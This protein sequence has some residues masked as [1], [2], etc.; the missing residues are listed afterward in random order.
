ME[1]WLCVPG[2]DGQYAVS[3]LGR[4][5]NVHRNSFKVFFMSP[6]GYYRVG[7]YIK[8]RGTKYQ[9]HRV[10]AQAFVPNPKRKPAI[11]HKDGN[12]L[13]NCSKNL[14][15]C[16]Y[17]ENSQHA[18]KMMLLSHGENHWLAKLN[19]FQVRVIRKS[20]DLTGIELSKIFNI[21]TANISSIKKRQTWKCV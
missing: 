8:G 21:T 7:F 14:E 6:Q 4:I 20:S 5:K 1:S 11:N 18:S 2:Y 3:N 17:K 9:V 12:K 10:V 19:E 13:N 15:W 16:T